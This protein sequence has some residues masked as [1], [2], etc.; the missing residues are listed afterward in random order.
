MNEEDKKR[1]EDIRA[2]LKWAVDTGHS[3]YWAMAQVGHDI[4]GLLSG[5]LPFTPRT[6][7]YAEY[8]EKEGGRI[9]PSKVSIRLIDGSWLDAAGV[10]YITKWLELSAAQWTRENSQES[11]AKVTVPWSSILFCVKKK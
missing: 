11:Y 1:I 9:M 3:F 5:N 4:S 8:A 7:G 10:H 6:A 2:F